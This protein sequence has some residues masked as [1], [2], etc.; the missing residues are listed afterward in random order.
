MKCMEHITRLALAITWRHNVLNFT[1]LC[2]HTSTIR[3]QERETCVQ[4]TNRNHETEG[5]VFNKGHILSEPAAKEPIEEIPGQ[6]R[7]MNGG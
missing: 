5:H 4:K 7:R 6:N 1:M 3:V 2:L